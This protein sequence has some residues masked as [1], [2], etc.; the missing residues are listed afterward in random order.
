MSSSPA[1]G[2]VVLAESATGGP[3]L[4]TY[5]PDTGWSESQ[6]LPGATALAAAPGGVA[7][8]NGGRVEV[9]AATN[10]SI[11]RSSVD[12]NWVGSAPVNGVAAL[13]VSSSG[14]LAFAFTEN[15][16]TSYATAGADGKIADVAVAPTEPFTPLIGW[17]DDSRRLV[18]STD[19]QQRSWIA[20]TGAKQAYTEL[21]ELVGCRWFAVSLDGGTLA[22]ATDSAVFVAATSGWLADE[23][24]ARLTS[25][26]TGSVVWGLALDR[27][28]A[29]L[30]FLTGVVADDGTVGATH[31]VIYA[32]SSGHWQKTL[33]IPVPFIKARGQ[34]WAG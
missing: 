21:N 5:G 29:R 8:T 30:A 10:P 2:L 14:R 6:P 22:A 7:V 3:A 32:S 9:R 11:V 1:D 27:A 18:L 13:A 17:L 33:D 31:E 15:R 20:V 12:L 25:I 28:G 23:E 34:A 16:R 19:K 26:A 4:W 24:P